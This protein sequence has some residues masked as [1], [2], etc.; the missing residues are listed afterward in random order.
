LQ[1]ALHIAKPF[2]FEEFSTD[3]I[4]FGTLFGIMPY[5]SETV[6]EYVMLGPW[7]SNPERNV[8]SYQAPFARFFMGKN[9]GDAVEVE[10][11]M[12]TGRYTVQS[13]HPIPEARIEAILQD[14]ESFT[15]GADR[16]EPEDISEEVEIPQTAPVLEADPVES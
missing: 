4:G 8:L 2:N 13:I 5:G 10:L 7:E 3:S 14:Q 12:H 6:E 15:G 1:E 16:S 11:P 9:V